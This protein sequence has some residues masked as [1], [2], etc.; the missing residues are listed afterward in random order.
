[1]ITLLKKIAIRPMGE[2]FNI[3]ELVNIMEGVDGA[4]AFGYSLETIAI[5]VEDNQK[6]QYKHTH[7]FDVRV[8]DESADNALIDAWIADQKRVQIA[9]EGVDGLFF[10]DNVLLTRNKQYDGIIAS[11]F[12]A[13]ADT[14]TWYTTGVQTLQPGNTAN[15]VTATWEKQQIYAATSLFDRF[16]KDVSVSYRT[17]GTNTY[18][19]G[20]VNSS[21]VVSNVNTTANTIK[22]ERD[23]PGVGTVYINTDT[24]F[25]PF[26]D[27]ILTATINV[28]DVNNGGG[29][30]PRFGIVWRGKK[31][32]SSNVGYGRTVTVTTTGTKTVAYK[33]ATMSNLTNQRDVC[34]YM[35]FAAD[36]AYIEYDSITFEVSQSIPSGLASQSTEELD[37]NK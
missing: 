37:G 10:M 30:D 5:Q 28:V 21:G 17:D 15:T 33:G 29:D 7:T 8:I 18:Q 31:D 23:D 12:L 13:T 14:L 24:F 27:V 25:M 22:I 19:H 32:G 3:V 20:W 34:L 35:S 11:A 4:A 26:P 9:G 6:Q 36:D 16:Q 2:P 1:M